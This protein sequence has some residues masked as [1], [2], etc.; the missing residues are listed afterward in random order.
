MIQHILKL[1]LLLPIAP[2]LYVEHRLGGKRPPPNDYHS[3]WQWWKF[4]VWGYYRH[5]FVRRK[6]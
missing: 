5:L 2:V 4:H 3:Y 1:M 6:P